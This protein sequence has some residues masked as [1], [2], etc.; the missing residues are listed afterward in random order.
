MLRLGSR[1]GR[2]AAAFVVAGA[3]LLATT[4]S[5]RADGISTLMANNTST[6]VLGDTTSPADC[7]ATFTGQ[8]DTAAG[9]T[10]PVFDPAGGDVSTRDI[11]SLL[12]PGST[13]KVYVNVMPG[14]CTPKDGSSSA[15]V[16]RC[17]SNVMT[18]YTENNTLTVDKQ[19]ADMARRGIDGASIDWYGPSS[20]AENPDAVALKF[21]SEIQSQGLCTAGPQK[22]KIMYMIMFDGASLKYA[23]NPTHVTGASNAACATSLAAQAA[24]S[25]IVARL[26]NDICYMNGLHFGNDAYQKYQGRPVVQFFVD[27]GEYGNLPKS[28]AAPSWPDLWSQV[29]GFSADLAGNCSSP[30]NAGAAHPY[31]V[32]NGAPLLV[33]ENAGG[34]SQSGSGG[35]FGWVLPSGSQSDYEITSTGTGRSIQEFYQAAA[36]NPGKL[37]WG[38]AYKGFNDSQSAWGAGRLIDQQ[39]GQTWVKSMQ[40]ANAFYSSSNQLPFLQVATWNDYNEGTSIED[41]VDNCYTVSAS[42]AGST[43]DWSLN[44]TSSAAST[45]TVAGFQVYDSTDG[46]ADYQPVGSMLPATARSF[47]LS[48]LAAGAHDVFV[49]MVGQPE[50]DN[51]ASGA[52]A[53]SH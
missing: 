40:E 3:A 25:C 24:E 49:E 39:C 10:T 53:Y 13:T 43:L 6:C 23:D 32:N 27:E 8:Q 33:F 15:S 50:I 52:V 1:A 34:F 21:Q 11:H 14:F 48:G 5:A 42:A 44:P 37:T 31:D 36:A 2:M 7:A 16:P 47:D 45:S 12:Y 51:Q 38:V 26:K 9:I 30:D 19:L 20:G 46:G 17:N 28:G 41:G 35:A 18:Q 4:G 22:C 29:S